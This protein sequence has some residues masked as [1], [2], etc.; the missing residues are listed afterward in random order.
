[1]C[2]LFGKVR[3]KCYLV[4]WPNPKCVSL[5]ITL[6]DEQHHGSSVKRNQRSHMCTYCV[7]A[8]SNTWIH[9]GIHLYVFDR[10][11]FF[12]IWIRLNIDCHYDHVWNVNIACNY[13]WAGHHRGM[14]AVQYG[15][16]L[17][18]WEGCFV[19]MA[20]R[21]YLDCSRVTWQELISLILH[22]RHQWRCTASQV[23]GS[24]GC[25]N[26]EVFISRRCGK[27]RWVRCAFK[28]LWWVTGVLTFAFCFYFELINTFFR[29]SWN[30]HYGFQAACVIH[31]SFYML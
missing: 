2:E 31:F 17:L 30:V 1:M 27:P 3:V 9:L 18:F 15:V 4:R 11:A 28:Q 25:V 12:F 20:D 8:E 10:T 7:L 16:V 5:Y 26:S 23:T 19:V 24:L 14:M 21:L 6:M 13:A 29:R 22:S